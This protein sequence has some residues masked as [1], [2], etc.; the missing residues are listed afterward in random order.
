MRSHRR[1]SLGDTAAAAVANRFN[2]H[3]P[4]M[5]FAERELLRRFLFEAFLETP[6]MTATWCVL[7]TGYRFVFAPRGGFGPKAERCCDFIGDTMAALQHRISS[8]RSYQGIRGPQFE[9]RFHSAPIRTAGELLACGIAV[10]ALPSRVGLA[11]GEGEYRFSGFAA[12][13]AGD[14]ESRAG[15]CRLLD[16]ADTAA[17]WRQ[18]SAA[19]RKLLERAPR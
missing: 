9:D 19:Y 6:W 10:D 8:A 17:G 5:A 15:I 14:A 12:A 3:V 13:L 11:A 2:E 16:K 7:P 18:A 1:D 4:A